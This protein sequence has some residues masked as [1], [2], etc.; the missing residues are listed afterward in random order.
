MQTAYP[1]NTSC[2]EGG[3]KQEGERVIRK[4]QKLPR[5]RS[6]CERIIRCVDATAAAASHPT[7]FEMRVGVNVA[8]DTLH[9]DTNRR[10]CRL[11][12]RCF[13]WAF[14]STLF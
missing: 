4:V 10:A 2:G 13:V 11:D 6:G 12:D 8:C 3:T 9:S 5:S 14:S 1:R 7:C